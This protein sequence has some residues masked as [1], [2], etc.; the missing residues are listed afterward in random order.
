MAMT[1]ALSSSQPFER[2]SLRKVLGFEDC[3]GHGVPD[4]GAEKL[5]RQ[6]NV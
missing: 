1:S 3:V 6:F 2:L 4:G 5:A